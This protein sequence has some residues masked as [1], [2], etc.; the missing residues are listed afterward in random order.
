MGQMVVQAG[1][2]GVIG[3]V[4]GRACLAGARG[5]WVHACV[6]GCTEWLPHAYFSTAG[7]VN[8]HCTHQAAG[9]HCEEQSVVL[10]LMDLEI[11]SPPTG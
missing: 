3:G 11:E 2:A 8:A 5:Q 7:R 6:G 4:C 9:V 1:G 10:L